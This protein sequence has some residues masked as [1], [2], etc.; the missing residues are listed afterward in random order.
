M[1]G[2]LAQLTTER[3]W[4]PLALALVVPKDPFVKGGP[5]SR[6]GHAGECDVPSGKAASPRIAPS[7]F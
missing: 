1:A 2:R 5:M 3:G 4:S 6:G 7:T